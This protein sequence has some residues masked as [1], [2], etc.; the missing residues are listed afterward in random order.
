MAYYVHNLTD[1]G[2][3]SHYH[4]EM[5]LHTH[6]VW[7]SENKFW[8]GLKKLESSDIAG[9]S[10][11]WVGPCRKEFGSSSPRWT[12]NCCK[13]NNFLARSTSQSTESRTQMLAPYCS[14]QHHSQSPKV[15]N[16]PNIHQLMMDKQLWAIHTVVYYSAIKR[17][18]LLKHTTSWLSHKNMSSESSRTQK[19][20]YGLFM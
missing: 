3:A 13:P 18:E 19:A 17:H 1:E 9:G 8:W 16:K 11:K 2:R 7:K 15:G 5:P 12:H 14:Q 20:T 10:V 6:E 4:D